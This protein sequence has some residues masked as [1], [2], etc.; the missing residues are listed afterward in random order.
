MNVICIDENISIDKK[1]IDNTY[2]SNNDYYP[3]KKDT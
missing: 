3:C 2:I 1:Y